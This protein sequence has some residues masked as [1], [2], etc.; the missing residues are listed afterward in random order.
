MAVRRKKTPPSTST[1]DVENSE[2]CR[3]LNWTKVESGVTALA[4]VVVAFS[5]TCEKLSMTRPKLASRSCL[6]RIGFSDSD[7]R[8][9]K[10]GEPAS[11]KACDMRIWN[12]SAVD[13]LVGT[14]T[15]YWGK[16]GK[17]ETGLD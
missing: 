11:P 6:R 2:Y 7:I 14:T 3:A 12:A 1:N 4:M 8:P 9:T 17:K 10:Y 5:A 13:L 15:Y 16:R